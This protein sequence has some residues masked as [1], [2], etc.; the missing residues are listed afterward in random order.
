MFTRRGKGA[1]RSGEGAHKV[2]HAENVA[3]LGPSPPKVDTGSPLQRAPRWFQRRYSQSAT[4][5]GVSQETPSSQ[6]SRGLEEDEW[7]MVR[8]QWR[9]KWQGFLAAFNLTPKTDPVFD[10]LLKLYAHR[11]RTEDLELLYDRSPEELAFYLPQLCQFVLC[12]PGDSITA[13]DLE[14]LL[15]DRCRR[16]FW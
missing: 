5:R 11:Q 10:L 2:C 16:K 3:T 7:E 15:L 12:F 1:F 14:T 8:A 13:V 6:A 9:K 4:Y